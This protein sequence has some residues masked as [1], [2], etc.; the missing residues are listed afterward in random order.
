M[1]SKGKQRMLFGVSTLTIC[2]MLT[3]CC[4]SHDWKEATC[5][6]PKT[7]AKCG[8]VEGEALG[9]TWTEATCAEPKTCSVCGE[10]E[11]EPLEHTLTDANYQQAAVCEVCGETVGEPLQ[12]DFEKG[13]L[14]KYI[15]Q[16]DQEYDYSTFCDESSSLPTM[17]KVQFSNYRT[18]DSD[19]TH[20]AQEGYNWKSMDV[21]LS[22]GDDTAYYFGASYIGTAADYYDTEKYNET[23]QE[24]DN[25]TTFTVNWNGVDYTE[26]RMIIGP[27][28]WSEWTDN[29]NPAYDWEHLITGKFSV[30][31]LLPVDYDG[32]LFGV[33]NRT[34]V[35]MYDK[36]IANAEELIYLRMQ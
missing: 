34:V 30:A 3:G 25:E 32:F 36:S 33:C 6:E 7:C 20:S 22:F 24:T 2:F 35:N 13:D 26:C 17:G 16:P 28:E 15:V 1:K 8:E 23:A 4:I 29:T 14:A 12:P 10:T 9:H 18:F 11:G 5:T 19:E 27:M 31:V 21:T